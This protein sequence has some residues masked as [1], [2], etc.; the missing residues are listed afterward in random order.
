MH[1][2]GARQTGVITE[3]YVRILG[4]LLHV[5]L[6][7][8]DDDREVGAF[9]TN[10]DCVGNVGREFEFVLQFAGGDVFAA[11]CD[12]DVLHAVCDAEEPFLVHQAHVTGVQP[13]V[14]VD[15]F[16]GLLGQVQV[17]HE[18]I[19]TSHQDFARGR[20]EP[21]F[22]ETSRWA[23]GARLHAGGGHAGRCTA[24]FRHAPHLQH[25]NTQGHVPLH[26]F[27][28]DGGRPGHAKAC[29]VDADELAR[30]VQGQPACQREAQFQ[31]GSHGLA[32]HHL[33]GNAHAYANA[34]CVSCTLQRTRF[35][36]GDHHAGIELLPNAGHGGEHRGGNLAHVLGN[37]FG[38]LDK[39]QFG[40][41]IERKVL[42]AHALGNVA[43]GQEAHAFIA[44]VLR[45]Q[46]VEA[47]RG[48]DQSAVAV[49][50]SLGLAGGAR[51]VDQNGKV[52]GLAVGR[53]LLHRVGVFFQ[54]VAAQGPQGVE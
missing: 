30:I 52:L 37:R 9:V 3:G 34:P 19:G 51:G 14:R 40:A 49:H 24:G 13:A 47:A 50:G 33:L 45:H 17:A 31:A 43:Q 44:L 48:V 16:G 10:D 27:G 46:G 22:V 5:F 4:K 32:R 1:F 21:H 7:D 41:G 53:T 8:H 54:P 11:R 15:G 39:I 2:R 6:V 26:Q 36:E 12:D 23:N 28:R 35:L 25:G 18:D 29:A 38:V 42:S 20:V